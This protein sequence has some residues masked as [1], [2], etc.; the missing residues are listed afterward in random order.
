MGPGNTNLEQAYSFNFNILNLNRY[1]QRD[2]RR[3]VLKIHNIL[4]YLEN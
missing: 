2:L 3:N 4:K 1:L